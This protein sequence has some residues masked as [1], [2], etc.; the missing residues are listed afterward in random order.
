[1]VREHGQTEWAKRMM[2]WRCF[3]GAL[4]EGEWNWFFEQHATSSMNVTLALADLLL[5]ADLRPELPSLKMPMLIFSPDSSPFISI[6]LMADI[7][8][9]VAGS[10]MQVVPHTKHGLP[11]SH[12]TMCASTLREF[13]SRRFSAS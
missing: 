2:E 6:D 13:L 7:H 11:L 12:G 5:G 8:R 10:E 3:P 9:A 4:D 1:M